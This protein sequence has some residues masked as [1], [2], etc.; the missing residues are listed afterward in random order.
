MVCRRPPRLHDVLYIGPVRIFYTMCTL[1][2][3][4][5]FT[6]E[7][8]VELVIGELLHSAAANAVGILAY[9]AMPDHLHYLA[10]GLTESADLNRF[11]RLFRQRSGY[12]FQR[13]CRERLW[14]D[15][16][17]DRQWYPVRSPKGS[18]SDRYDPLA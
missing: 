12:A 5:R 11:T 13:R 18:R 1:D 15:G 10:E 14:Q 8:I 3:R 16:Y 7:P 4:R 6:T 9:C 17:F 2:R